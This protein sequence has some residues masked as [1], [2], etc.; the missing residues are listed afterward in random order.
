MEADSAIIAVASDTVTAKAVKHANVT[1]ESFGLIPRILEEGEWL[2]GGDTAIRHALAVIDG[3]HWIL[4]M[5]RSSSGYIQVR[6][7]F[8][9]NEKRHREIQSR[10]R[11]LKA[12]RDG[13]VAGGS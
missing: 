2:D 12:L 10:E 8:A 1:V 11:R 9:G 5:R 7:L 4:A 3:V 6:T 13:S